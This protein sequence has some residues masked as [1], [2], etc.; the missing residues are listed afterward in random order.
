MVV[1]QVET[2]SPHS[3]CTEDQAKDKEPLLCFLCGVEVGFTIRVG[4]IFFVYIRKG[5]ADPCVCSS[6]QMTLK[7]KIILQS[8]MSTLVIPLL[9]HNEVGGISQ[10]HLTDQ[11]IKTQQEATSL[12]LCTSSAVRPQV[13]HMPFTQKQF[14]LQ[15]TEHPAQASPE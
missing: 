9:S 12:G 2:C 4:R 6:P 5:Q 10:P 14:T 3:N 13:D 1:G 11:E 7:T 8:R 15:L